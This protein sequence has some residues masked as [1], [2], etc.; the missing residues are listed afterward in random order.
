MFKYIISIAFAVLNVGFTFSQVTRI[1]PIGDTYIESSSGTTS[2]W[3]AD[4]LRLK[5]SFSKSSERSAWIKFE[6]KNFPANSAQVL[7]KLVKTKGDEGN[8]SITSANP[9]FTNTATWNN[10]PKADQLFLYGGKRVGDTC[11]IDVTDF[12]KN[13]YTNASNIAFQLFTTSYIVTPISFA[14]MEAADVKSRPELLFYTNKKYDLPLFSLYQSTNIKTGNGTYK[15]DLLSKT[16]STAEVRN[17][18]GGLVDAKSKATGYFRVEKDCEGTWY[19][20]DPLGNIF[21]ST[22]LNSVENGGGI[23]LPTELKNM[24]INTMGCWSDETIKGMAYTPRF[25]VLNSFKNSSDRLK[26]MYELTI[27]PVFEPDFASFCQNLA[28]TSLTPY[29][30]DPWVLG[31][32]LDNE[33]PFY[34]NQLS[35]S[36]GLTSTDPQYIAADKWMKTKYGA[37]YTLASITATDELDY[38]GYVAEV[39]FKTISEAFRAVDPNHMLIGTRFHGAGKYVTQLFESAGKYMDIISINY[40]GRFEP[41]EDA[42][43]MWLNSGKKPFIITEFYTKGDDSGLGNADGAGW[44]VPTQQDRANWFENWA[45]KLLRN[46]GSVGY[47][48]FRYM[49]KEGNDS[50]KGV[51]S[52]TYVQYQVLANSI[53]KVSTSIYSLRSQVLYGNSNYNDVINCDKVLCGSKANCSPVL[54]NEMNL[55]ENLSYSIYPNPTQSSFTIKGGKGARVEIINVFGQVENE[56]WIDQDDFLVNI[57]SFKKGVYIVKI[58]QRDSIISTKIIKE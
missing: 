45:L 57:H 27:L 23:S 16:I 15:A 4:V 20:I 33:L 58:E 17:T 34:K 29:L 43:D 46:K 26:A 51:Y 37:S 18:Y 39:Y 49:D 19:I 9:S 5:H 28:K 38:Q 12:F 10:P 54:A 48:W 42:M 52:G 6:T 30:K 22:G 1:S 55:D 56:F 32:F 13:H 21:Y 14:S 11:F 36:L 8:I 41:E 3:T 50:N 25:N 47:H 44:S 40:Y 2:Y 24:G 53:A 7:L 31:Y 35:L